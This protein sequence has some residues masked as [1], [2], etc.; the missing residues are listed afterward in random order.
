MLKI[1]FFISLMNSFIYSEVLSCAHFMYFN[2][3]TGVQKKYTKEESM[4][5][6]L[7]VFSVSSE[8]IY[9]DLPSGNKERFDFKDI[10]NKDIR[11]FSKNNYYLR[12]S[13]EHKEIW[14]WDMRLNGELQSIMLFCGLSKSRAEYE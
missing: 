4:K 5:M 14:W 10:I 9:V 2:H 12:N 3:T 7:F 1:L 6:P 13:Q 11:Y 8:V